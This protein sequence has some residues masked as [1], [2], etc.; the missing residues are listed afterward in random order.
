MPTLT[1][2]ERFRREVPELTLVQDSSRVASQI[3]KAIQGLSDEALF[4][5]AIDDSNAAKAARAGLLLLAGGLEDA[6]RIVQDFDTPEARYWH[7]I[8]HRRE[9]DPSNAKYWF[10]QLGHHAVFS[11]LART[12]TLED[13]L[14]KKTINH[15]LQ[16][17]RWDPFRFVDLCDDCEKG[18]GADLLND[19]LMIQKKEIDLLLQFCIQKAL[20]ASM[21]IVRDP[22]Q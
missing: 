22:I 13:S 3:I 14:K 16:S 10:R 15:I 7:G 18:R 19:F 9:P 1:P 21:T 6:H 2:Y 8:V 11:D 4:G 20:G 12:V 17:G 5:G